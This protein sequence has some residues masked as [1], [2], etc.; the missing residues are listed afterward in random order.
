[1]NSSENLAEK[2]VKMNNVV[3]E[4]GSCLFTVVLWGLQIAFWV[5]FLMKLPWWVILFYPLFYVATIFLTATICYFVESIF[6][7]WNKNNF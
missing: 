5:W 3:K 2:G 6:K 4:G 1:M 7:I